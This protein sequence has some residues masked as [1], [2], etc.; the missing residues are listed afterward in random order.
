MCVFFC[1]GGQRTGDLD[2]GD[3]NNGPVALDGGDCNNG[4]ASWMEGIKGMEGIN[5][6]GLLSTFHTELLGLS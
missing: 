3:C 4:L 1:R 2:G 6:D 5:G